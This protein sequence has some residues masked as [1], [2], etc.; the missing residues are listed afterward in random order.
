MSARP[1]APVAYILPSFPELAQTFVLGEIVEVER[2]GVSLLIVSLRRPRGRRQQADVG[3]VR[4]PVYQCPPIWSPAVLQ[5]NWRL[6][7]RHPGRTLGLVAWLIRAWLRDRRL[8]AGEAGVRGRLNLFERLRGRFHAGRFFIL[9][10]TLALVPRAVHLSEVLAA[11]GVERVHA[12]WASYPATVALLV[13]RLSG[14]AFSFTAHAYDIYMVSSMLAEKVSQACAVVTCADANRRYLERRL[15]AA[16]RGKIAVCHHGVD[17]DRFR[18]RIHLTPARPARLIACGQLEAYKGFEFLLFACALLRHR[19]IPFSCRI[20]GEGPR[21]AR[22]EW[23]RDRLGLREV[24]ALP[25]A[26]THD[27]LVPEMAR[28]TICVMPSIVLSGY[29]KRDVIPNAVIEAMAMGLPVVAAAVG[30]IGEAIRD[31]VS[32][33]IVPPGDAAALADALARLLADPALRARLARNALRHARR[34]FD[35]RANA[36]RLVDL[37]RLAGSGAA[38]PR[39]TVAAAHVEGGVA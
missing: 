29:G 19:G 32:G 24:V 20:I 26:V 16:A 25:G 11:A 36:R 15:G 27:E 33:S 14:T 23:L 18:P 10:K 4:A 34:H 35:R 9:L 37:L 3:A 28:A 21:R 8:A 13:R 6:I 39:P 1:V 2:L 38:V 22:L 31:G 5:A 30:G 12:H 17:L 7:R